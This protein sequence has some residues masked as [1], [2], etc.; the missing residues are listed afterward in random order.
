[1]FEE[2]ASEKVEHVAKQ[3]EYVEHEVPEDTDHDVTITRSFQ[4]FCTIWNMSIIAEEVDMSLRP[5]SLSKAISFVEDSEYVEC[6]CGVKRL[7]LWQRWDYGAV[8]SCKSLYGVG[9]CREAPS[10]SLIYLLLYVDDMLVA[11]KDME[12]IKKLKIL[13]NTE[14]DMK[15]LGA[16]RK[17]LG[18][19]I[20]R[21][22]PDIAHAMSVCV[23][24]YGSSWKRSWNAVKRIFRYLKGTSDVGLIYGGEREYLVAGY[25][26]SDY[27]ADLDARRSL[28]GYVFTIGSSVCDLIV[29]VEVPIG[30][31][32]LWSVEVDS[33]EPWLVSVDIMMNAGFKFDYCNVGL[34]VMWKLVE[35]LMMP[36]KSKAP[37]TENKPTEGGVKWSFAAGSNFLPNF[38]AKIERESKLRLHDFAKEL[39]SFSIV[40]MSGRN[41][42]DEGVAEDVSFAANGITA[43]GIKAFDGILQSN[44]TL[45]TLNLSG[46]TIG[47]EGAKILAD[48]L[49]D[50]TGILKLQLNSTG[51]GDDG[52]KAIAEMLKKNSTLRTV[53]LN[54]NLIDYSGFSGLAEALLENK[55]LQS[56]YLNGNYGGA[57]G[58]SALAKGLEGNKALRE[59]FLHGNSI[60]DEGVRALITGLSLHKGKLTA[61]DIGNNMIT[62]KGAFHVAEYVKRSKSLLWLNIYMNDIKDEGAEKIAEALKENRSITNIDLGGNDIHAK[63]ITAIAEV[64]KDN[65]VITAAVFGN[66]RF[67]AFRSDKRCSTNRENLS[68]IVS[69]QILQFHELE[70]GYNPM[71][72]DGAKA[73]S[74]VLKFHGNIKTLMLG[75]CKIGPKG[76][77]FIADTLKYNNTISTLD[78]RAN[79]L[80]DEGAK[81]LARSLKVVNEALVSLDLGFNEIRDEGAFSISQALKAN[82]DVRL[83][84]LNLA[85]NFLTKLGQLQNAAM[86]DCGKAARAPTKC[87]RKTVNKDSGEPK[88]PA[89]INSGGE[90]GCSEVGGGEVGCDEVGD[91]GESVL[92]D[93]RV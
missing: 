35:K 81:S 69:D 25:S 20:I 1:M 38:G 71:G 17:I 43:E 49:V 21:E 88:I 16:A 77:E 26:D 3:V 14:F 24:V 19:E 86:D 59:L 45:K 47:D 56:L 60:G 48:I 36:K 91:G 32:N 34:T 58:A 4:I 41:F 93:E 10:G 90:V 83:A 73:L 82:E 76:A 31:R 68:E 7:N 44:I 37:G 5:A 13:L 6:G 84:S 33:R 50:N 85:S 87:R 11:A 8:G 30:Q 79:G 27:A 61:L 15:D 62:S 64:L 78:L 51:L 72:P 57:L 46:N 40:D 2:G 18:M 89:K 29:F 67:G 75:W 66:K 54:N 12:E 53:E 55:S 39:R 22:G 65:G 9:N 23:S 74:D 80:S 70:L 52:A 42:G 63:G 28:T 92:R